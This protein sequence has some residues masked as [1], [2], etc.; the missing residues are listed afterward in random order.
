MNRTN[1]PS[2][3]KRQK[4]DSQGINIHK[5]KERLLQQDEN[6]KS[7]QY[8]DFPE[9]TTQWQLSQWKKRPSSS[10]PSF[11][12]ETKILSPSL[13]K[14]RKRVSITISNDPLFQSVPIQQDNQ[15]LPET[16]DENQS[17]M[18]LYHCL[19]DP[20]FDLRNKQR[21]QNSSFIDS[22][23]ETEEYPSTKAEQCFQQQW[24]LSTCSESTPETY[25]TGNLQQLDSPQKQND[26][27][28]SNL[29]QIQQSTLPNSIST[30]NEEPFSTIF[31]ETIH[32]PQSWL[33]YEN[34]SHENIDQ[35]QLSLFW[36]D[37]F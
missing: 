33:S 18:L 9:S 23:K 34:E 7:I 27:S 10:T 5:S 24:K 20:N 31:P 2:V 22:D 16:K 12:E 6:T 8:L 26:W 1:V 11:Y 4:S 17:E 37:F 21:P 36:T 14:L 13:N 25:T 19:T 3:L 29:W 30:E 35:D 28:L 32:F 15:S